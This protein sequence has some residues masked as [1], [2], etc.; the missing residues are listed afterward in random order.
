[1]LSKNDTLQELILTL[2][3]C[4]QRRCRSGDYTCLGRWENRMHY[5]LALNTL[6]AREVTMEGSSTD[7]VLTQSTTCYATTSF[8]FNLEHEFPILSL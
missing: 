1:M 8:T 2:G 6:K 4:F 5:W 7:F 3:R